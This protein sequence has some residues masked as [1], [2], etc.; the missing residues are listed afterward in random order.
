MYETKN[1][2]KELLEFLNFLN[3]SDEIK[4]DVATFFI[5]K[6]FNVSFSKSPIKFSL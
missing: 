3:G 6:F 5:D 1:D 4:N 2:D